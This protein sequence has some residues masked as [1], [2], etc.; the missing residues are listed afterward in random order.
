MEEVGHWT[1]VFEGYVFYWVLSCLTLL[2][3]HCENNLALIWF[4]MVVKK[5]LL[6]WK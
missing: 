3:S 4:S 5:V 6:S 1:R 2:P